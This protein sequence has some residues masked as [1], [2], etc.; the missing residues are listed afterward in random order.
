MFSLMNR[1]HNT[2]FDI[3]L[4]DF[5]GRDERNYGSTQ[6]RANIDETDRGYSITVEM[7]GLSRS[8]IEV[9]TENDLLTVTGNREVNGTKSTYSRSWSLG[10]NVMQDGISARYDAGILYVEVPVQ[11]TMKR[12]I[13]VE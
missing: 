2:T 3:F 13:S 7:P 1:N 11:K 4:E 10:E 5:I 9:S 8:N 12:V 6:P